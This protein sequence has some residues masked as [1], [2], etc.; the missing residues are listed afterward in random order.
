MARLRSLAGLQLVGCLALA[1]CGG[2]PQLPSLPTAS[3]P[4]LSVGETGVVVASTTEVYS[5]IARGANR[6]WFGAAGRL[7]KSHILYADAE[8]PQ[9][10]GAV[11]III[12]ERAVDQ[13]KIW[14][15]KA[16]RVS[17]TESGGQSVVGVE[18]MRMP[19]DE[20][21]RMQTEVLRWA[22]GREECEVTL[23]PPAPAVDV[24][25]KVLP[26]MTP[27]LQPKR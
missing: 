17:I 18:N 24:A 22:N 14:G 21:S 10:G 15:F 16:Y 13:P 19:D 8:S 27:V 12:H 1:A 4:K 11:E 5:R 26:K 7:A 23:S 6:C 25:P 2:G 9:K 3:L 20:H